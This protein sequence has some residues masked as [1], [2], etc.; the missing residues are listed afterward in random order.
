FVAVLLAIGLVIVLVLT[1]TAIT[2]GVAS[3]ALVVAYPYMKRLTYWP[4]A[5]LGLTFNWGALMGWAAVTDG[6]D[7]APLAL[8]AAGIAWTLHYD[9][10]YAHQDKEDDALVGVKS[11]ALLLGPRTRRWLALFAVL[12]VAGF[13]LALWLG[14]TGWPGALALVAVAAHLAWQTATVNIDDPADC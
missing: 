5:F 12:A 6:L 2:L 13:G 14:G 1:P 3:L 8:Y 10:I 9:T 7:L 11:T 4:Q